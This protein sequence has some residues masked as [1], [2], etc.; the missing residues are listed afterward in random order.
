MGPLPAPAHLARPPRVPGAYAAVRG[1]RALGSLPVEAR[2]AGSQRDEQPAVVVVGGEH[3]RLHGSPGAVRG[4]QLELLVQP[5]HAPLEREGHGIPCFLETGDPKCVDELLAHQ[6]ALAVPGQLEDAAAEREHAAFPV[7][8]HE[9]RR[10]RRVVVVHQLEE[11]PEAAAVAA[12]RLAVEQALEAVGVDGA[13]LAVRADEV[14][15]NLSVAAPTTTS[16]GGSTTPG[17]RW[18]RR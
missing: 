4:R 13:L 6:V 5:P 2:L 11:E 18:W 12:D 10:G 16:G 8:H 15:H 3:V 17:A 1:V 9:A 7:A 14:G